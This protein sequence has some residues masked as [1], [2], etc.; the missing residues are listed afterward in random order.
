[1]IDVQNIRMNASH[2]SFLSRLGP[3]A[4]SHCICIALRSLVEA[5]CKLMACCCCPRAGGGNCR[6]H[7]IRRVLQ[8]SHPLGRQRERHLVCV[9]AFMQAPKALLAQ[10]APPVLSMQIIKYGVAS[11]A[12]LQRDLASWD[13]LYLAGR[14]QKPTLT[15]G[16]LHPAVAAAQEHNLQSA[17]RASLLLLP[18]TFTLREL[19][20]T[21]C[22]LSYAGDLRMGLAEDSKKVERIVEGAGQGHFTLCHHFFTAP[23]MFHVLK[24]GVLCMCPWLQVARAVLTYQ[25]LFTHAVV[26]VAVK[27]CNRCTRHP[28]AWLSKRGALCSS[29]SRG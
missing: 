11:L 22:G 13:A 5:A 16:P 28:L 24:V 14:M 19:L 26:Q 1:M 12:G 18:E 21:V 15:L 27:A 23:C 6:A 25:R 29:S 10:P 8:H 3:A 17:V 4:V 7:R 2:Y 9:A 20:H